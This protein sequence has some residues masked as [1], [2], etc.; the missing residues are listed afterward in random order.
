MN[1]AIIRVI[2]EGASAVSYLA[3]NSQGEHILLKRYKTALTEKGEVRWQREAELLRS[4]E[5]L[6]IPKYINH[7]VKEFEGRRL[8]HLE[9]EFIEGQCFAS[10]LST[11]RLPLSQALAF[12]RDLL[13]ILTYLHGIQPPIIHRDIKPSNLIIREDETLVL[14]DFGLAVDDLH[15]INYQVSV[16]RS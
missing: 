3:K 7:Y 2:G 4:I 8:P 13:H 15:I 14:I 9:M 16:I 11:K 6:Q 1:S 5:H 12:L 10:F